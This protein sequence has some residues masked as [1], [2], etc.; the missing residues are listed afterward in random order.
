MVE[1]KIAM[2]VEVED[3]QGVHRVGQLVEDVESMFH[4]IRVGDTV[5]FYNQQVGHTLYRVDVVD[6]KR[7]VRQRDIYPI[8]SLPSDFIGRFP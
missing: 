8:K 4:G 5:M 1:D 6:V 3:L 2:D 7:V